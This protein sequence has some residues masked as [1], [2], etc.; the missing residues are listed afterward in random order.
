MDSMQP[1]PFEAAF[2]GTYEAL[3]A[4]QSVVDGIAE[5]V[6]ESKAFTKALLDSLALSA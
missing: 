4:L 1:N 5:Q 2:K 3:D 6:R